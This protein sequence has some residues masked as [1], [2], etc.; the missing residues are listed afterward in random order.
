MVYGMPKTSIAVGRKAHFCDMA[1]Y[2]KKLSSGEYAYFLSPL[3][4]QLCTLFC[5]LKW[6]YEHF[7]MFSMV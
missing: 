3:K 5:P 6:S 7:R 1:H 4:V 2:V